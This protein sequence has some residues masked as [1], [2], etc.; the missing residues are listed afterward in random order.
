VKQLGT[1]W[2]VVGAACLAAACA[3]VG[4]LVTL[5][6]GRYDPSGIAVDAADVYWAE[7]TASHTIMK[8]TKQ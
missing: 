8:T 1:R 6:S 3:D 5:A 2:A 4:A 7:G